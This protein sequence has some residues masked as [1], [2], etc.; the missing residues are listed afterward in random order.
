VHTYDAQEGTDRPEP[1]PGAAALDGVPEFLTVA[2]GAMPAWHPWP[3]PT[4]RVGVRTAEGPAWVL[5]LS[6]EGP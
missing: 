4:A 3:H 6:A 1:L 5:S 2:C